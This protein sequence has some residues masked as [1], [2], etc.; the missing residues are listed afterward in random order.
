MGILM[1]VNYKGLGEDDYGRERKDVA[2]TAVGFIIESTLCYRI[3]STWWQGNQ[4]F[5]LS[6]LSLIGQRGP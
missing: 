2:S 4:L 6:S 5:S 1:K 3:S